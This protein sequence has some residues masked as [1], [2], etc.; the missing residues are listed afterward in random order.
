MNINNSLK[1]RWKTIKKRKSVGAQIL[2]NIPRRS[3]QSK[4]RDNVS[5]TFSNLTSSSSLLKNL[6]KK[7]QRR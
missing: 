4:P 7:K 1:K 2:K 3:Y 5:L 6:E